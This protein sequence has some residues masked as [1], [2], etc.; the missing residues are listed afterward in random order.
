MGDVSALPCFLSV[1]LTIFD[2]TQK[3]V[4]YCFRTFEA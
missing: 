3:M 4:I 2:V 1:K